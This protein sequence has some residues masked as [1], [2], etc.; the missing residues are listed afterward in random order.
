[1]LT[2]TGSWRRRGN[3][4]RFVASRASRKKAQTLVSGRFRATD[5][6]DYFRMADSEVESI[7]C[8]D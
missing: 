8:L 7:G 4:G 2:R 3:N 5:E 6:V 1:M